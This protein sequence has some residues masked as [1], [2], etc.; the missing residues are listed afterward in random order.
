MRGLRVARG[1]AGRVRSV[2]CKTHTAAE[3]IK[4]QAPARI[5]AAAAQLVVRNAASPLRVEVDP[6]LRVRA[7]CVL[8][9]VDVHAD[10][11]ARGGG[12]GVTQPA[13]EVLQV[14]AGTRSLW[15]FNDTSL[16]YE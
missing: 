11:A 12:L 5:A 4:Q 8:V 15:L 3:G 14:P 6:V 1:V 9:G 7:V 10:G 2:T 13:A 16:R